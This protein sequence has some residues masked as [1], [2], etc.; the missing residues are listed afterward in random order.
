MPQRSRH[1][2]RLVDRRRYANPVQRARKQAKAKWA[3]A[4]YRD[5]EYLAAREALQ[6]E[7]KPCWMCLRDG[8]FPVARAVLPD[9]CPPKGK[10]A[11]VAQWRADGGVLK[12]ACYSCNARDGAKFGN[13]DEERMSFD[14]VLG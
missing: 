1:R 14:Y 11:T 13:S 10:Y 6:H 4:F 7:A 12:P 9:H 5:P 8:K 2:T 3:N